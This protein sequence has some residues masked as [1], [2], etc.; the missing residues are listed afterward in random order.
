MA[1]EKSDSDEE[2]DSRE[3][4]IVLLGVSGA[5]KSSTGNA[6]LGREAFKENRTRESEKQRGRVED[7]NISIIDTPGFF[8][9]H[10]SKDELLRQM[11]R[12]LYFSHPGPHVFL[13]VI[14]LENFREEQRNIVEQIQENFGDQALKFTMPLFIGREN[15]S[16]TEWIQITQSENTKQLL[17]YFKGIFHVMNSKEDCDPY[18]ITML[19]K[20][21]DEMV[22]NNEE[23]HYSGVIYYQKNLR[24]LNEQDRVDQ[25]ELDIRQER[26]TVQEQKRRVNQEEKVDTK[27]EERSKDD[28]QRRQ[29]EVNEWRGCR[30]VQTDLNR[31]QTE[32]QREGWNLQEEIITRHALKQDLKIVLLGKCGAGKTSARNTILGRKTPLVQIH[33][34]ACK[35]KE[36]DVCGRNISVI[37]TP[38]FLDDALH[39]EKLKSAIERSV[40]MSDPGPHAFLLVI[41]LYYYKAMKNT[42]RWVQENIEPCVLTHTIV[43]FTSTDWMSWL[44]CP[45][46][47]EYV[48]TNSCVRSLVDS[49]GGR[50][51]SLNNKDRHNHFQVNKLLEKIEELVKRNGGR[52]YAKQNIFKK[53]P[54]K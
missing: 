31:T 8:N 18:Q 9:T 3:L 24:K 19:L 15:I 33:T 21:I 47:D 52:P 10:L 42:V 1:T 53:A 16:K 29:E 12:C 4:R 5:G 11:L 48:A 50:Y 20:R 2:H 7:R 54:K 27:S 14:N 6:I 46:L 51:H 34:L 26:D 36:A 43:L 17:S 39:N 38:G 28:N 35:T 44:K 30:L 41:S 37:D 25:E 40:F 32:S 13:L 49:C 23:R 45:A 22:R